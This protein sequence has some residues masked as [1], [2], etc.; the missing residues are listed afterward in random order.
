MP[1]LQAGAGAFHPP[2]LAQDVAASQLLASGSD[3]YE[4]GVRDVQARILGIPA[5]D[6]YP[7]F[8]HPPVTVIVTWPFVHLTFGVA[9]Q[10][11]FAASL[12]LLFVLAVLLAEIV[13]GKDLGPVG[14]GPSTTTTTILFASLL[15]WP[16]VLYNLEKGQ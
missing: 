8:P 12:A 13:S 14:G 15:A 11:W 7:Y 4:T 5:H 2:D 1:W 3:P 10:V 16:P 9:A 6:G